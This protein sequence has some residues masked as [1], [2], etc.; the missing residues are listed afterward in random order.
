MG[1]KA[2]TPKGKYIYFDEEKHI[3]I[4]DK[5]RLISV[6][7]ILKKHTKPFDADFHAKKKSEET[8]Y[9]VKDIKK[10]WDKLR[11]EGAE[12]GTK[13]H[14]YLLY[15]LSNDRTIVRKITSDSEDDEMYFEI[16]RNLAK[17]ILKKY[18]II[19]TEFIIGSPELGIAGM[20]DLILQEKDSGKIVVADFKTGKPIIK[21]NKWEKLL[22]PLDNIENCNFNKYSLQ[23]SLYKYIFLYEKYFKKIDGLLII[24]ITKCE[25]NIYKARYYKKEVKKLLGD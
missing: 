11:E 21:K 4:C 15:L 1:L 5:K 23:L 2:K 17:D 18:N 10:S 13:V 6:T 20:V 3:Y 12:V 14:N 25:Y 19:G 24:H 7:Q 9:S 22:P 16:A 8:G